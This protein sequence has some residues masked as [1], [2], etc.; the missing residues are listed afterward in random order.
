MEG[1]GLI[2]TD[3]KVYDG[4]SDTDN[5]T[6]IDHIQFSYNQGIYLFGSA[7]MYEFV[8]LLTMPCHDSWHSEAMKTQLT[9]P[10]TNQSST[11]QARLEGL[12]NSTDI[13]FKDGVMYEQACE[14]VNTVGTCDTDQQSFKA[15]LSRWMAATAKLVPAYHDTIMALLKTSASAAASQCSGGTDGVTCG[16]HWYQS[17]DGLYGLGQQMSALSVVQSML[18][19]EAPALVTN[20]T[21]GTSQGN[22]NAGSQSSSSSEVITP[23]TSGDRAGAGIL[24]ALVISGLL[25]GVGM[26]VTG[27]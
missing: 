15:Y 14:P 12:L 10:Q 24:T 11:W 6:S 16:E 27:S 26:M 18:I 3:Y 9:Q 5:C 20:S 17:Y 13:F 7:V 19:D 8:S 23:A 1:V 4:T 22:V 2:S 25:G 21:G